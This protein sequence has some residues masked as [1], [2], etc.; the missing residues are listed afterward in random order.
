MAYFFS[1]SEPEATARPEPTRNGNNLKGFDRFYHIYI[2]SWPSNVESH[3]D[4]LSSL[5]EEFICTPSPSSRSTNAPFEW[6][7]LGDHEKQ[8][9]V[10]AERLGNFP[11]RGIRC[12]TQTCFMGNF[13]LLH[14]HSQY[15]SRSWSKQRLNYGT[16]HGL[17]RFIKGIF[18]T[19]WSQWQRALDFCM[20]ANESFWRN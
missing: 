12:L 18:S 4:A 10:S 9:K 19:S 13:S 17:K 8:F 6:G 1:C 7:R 15:H 11:L 2:Q 5:V 16:R 14:I 20:F 3:S